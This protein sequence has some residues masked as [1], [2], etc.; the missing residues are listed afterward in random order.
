MR[1]IAFAVITHLVMGTVDRARIDALYRV[2]RQYSRGPAV[3]CTWLSPVAG[4][5][6]DWLWRA[7]QR[8]EADLDGFLR[9]EIITHGALGNAA[10]HTDVAG[11]LLRMLTTDNGG[12]D[13]AALI[14]EIRA[15][16]IVG[17]E[18]TA[19]AMTWAIERLVH[20]PRALARA[21]EAIRSGDAAYLKALIQEALRCRP[22][23]V[24]AVRELTKP[25]RVA[26]HRLEARTLVFTSPLLTHFRADVYARP[27]HFDPARSLGRAPD[28]RCWLPFGGGVRG[29]LGSS[30]AMFEMA[31]G[32]EKIL[33]RVRL[34]PATRG[35]ERPRLVGTML[36]PSRGGRVIAA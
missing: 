26:S 6:R 20:N 21:V 13:D 14:E 28:P 12:L 9:A 7:V 19:A 10:G 8:R 5:A 15:L 30:L 11:T 31:V 23:V 25:I 29:C 35:S 3:G 2:V 16:L 18:T 36:V 32:L 24:D 4:P 22:P 17:H 34:V 33:S 27:D 1:A